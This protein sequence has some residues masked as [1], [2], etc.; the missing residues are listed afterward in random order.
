MQKTDTRTD[1]DGALFRIR[2]GYRPL[3]MA[4]VCLILVGLSTVHASSNHDGNLS[5]M[6][7]LNPANM[8][9][10]RAVNRALVPGLRVPHAGFMQKF[11]SPT[12][13]AE[14][15]FGGNKDKRPNGFDNDFDSFLFGGDTMFAETTLLG[16][17]INYTDADGTNAGGARNTLESLTPTL[18]VNRPIND[19]LYWG[20]SLSYSTSESKVNAAKT[21]SDSVVLSPYIMAMMQMDQLTLSLTPTYVLGLQEVDYS[22]NTTDNAAVGRLL[23]MGRAAYM[24]IE[25]L[26]VAVLLNYNQVIHNHALTSET[27]N[28]HR[29]F[30]TGF[31]VNYQITDHIG[32]YAGYELDFD[33]NFD[34]DFASIGASYTF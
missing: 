14:Y 5:I 27:D 30:T 32:A 16:A 8:A 3:A 15:G 33:S 17:M 2:I 24:V 22:N 11:S 9:V 34:S 10:E 26:N 6:N 12:L 20:A 1:L 4:L 18:Y 21:D 25:N 13:F 31:K 23:L 29:W 19:W 28:D 7:P